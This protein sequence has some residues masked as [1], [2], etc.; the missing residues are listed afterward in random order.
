MPHQKLLEN[1]R[2]AAGATASTNEVRDF[3]LLELLRWFKL[4]F[5]DW[6]DAPKCCRCSKAT[7]SSG[8]V[9][10]TDAELAYGAGR[11]ENYQC[12]SCMQFTRFPRYNHPSKLLETR[13]GR[14]G[15]WANC[16][17]LCCRAVGFEARYVLDWTDHVWTEVYS[18]TFE[19]LSEELYIQSSL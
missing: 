10:P 7:H 11:V 15:E 9:S 2:L 16:F 6:M 18:G 4:E 3:M 1:A 5:F 14:C 13:C 12:S 19:T 17:T 8:M